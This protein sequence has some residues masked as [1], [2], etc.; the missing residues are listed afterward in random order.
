M[1]PAMLKFPWESLIHSVKK[2]KCD[3]SLD[4]IGIPD[5]LAEHSTWSIAQSWWIQIIKYQMIGKT[6][7][8]PWLE[9]EMCYNQH[10]IMPKYQ[11]T[12]L[13]FL[14]ATMGI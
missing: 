5:N 14:L 12:Q 8:L 3:G 7:L 4:K 2:E 1:I 10:A 11:R 6:S 13:Q 9:E